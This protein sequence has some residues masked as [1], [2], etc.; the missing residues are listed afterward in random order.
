MI[1]CLFKPIIK[2]L[3]IYVS[4]SYNGNIDTSVPGQNCCGETPLLNIVLGRTLYFRFIRYLMY[5]RGIF[6]L[7]SLN[8][9]QIMLTMY[10]IYKGK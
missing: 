6:A 3:K 9:N 1:V 4:F 7:F 10:N 5:N 2:Y 8:C